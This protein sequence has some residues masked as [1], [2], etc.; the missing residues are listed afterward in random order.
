MHSKKNKL[1]C[2]PGV[3]PR[4]SHKFDLFICPASGIS[5]TLN[6]TLK[7]AVVLLPQTPYNPPSHGFGGTGAARRSRSRGNGR[8]RLARLVGS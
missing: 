3:L 4:F 7:G 8:I 5:L 6:K 2:N 1:F